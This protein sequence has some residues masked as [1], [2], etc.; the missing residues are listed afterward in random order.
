MLKR[1][2]T[3][4]VAA[5]SLMAAACGGDDDSG[6]TD[7]PDPVTE[8]TAEDPTGDT[9]AETAT[10]STEADPGTADPKAIVRFQW[11]T[12]GGSNY[13]P[14]IAFNQFANIFLYPAYDRLTELTPDGEVVPM[15]AESWEFTE[16]D[17][18]L[19]LAL[20][21]DVVFHDGTPFNAEAVK[22]NIE[23]G[24]T[25]EASAVT[26]DLAS[27]AEVV[28]VDEFTVE[29]RLSGPGAAL[30]A[31]L[32]DRA[33]MMISP[34]AF[35]NTDLD[36]RP[37]GAGAYMVKDHTPGSVI[38]FEQFPEYWNPEMQTLAGVE[39]TMQ[40]DPEARLRALQDG[41]IDGTTLNPDQIEAAESAGLEVQ[42]RPTTGAFLLFLNMT[43]PGLD[44]PQVREAI[45]LAIDRE[46]IAEALHYGKCA[47]SGQVFPEGYW[48][49]SPNV[50]PDAFDTDRA[51]S[52][53]EDAGHGDGLALD[54][55]VVNVPFYV[56]QLEALQAQLGEIGIDLTVTALEPTE[57]LSRFNTGGA[58]M[59]FT[60][61][62][63]SVDPAKTVASIF[64]EQASLNPGG[65]T[66]P[67]MVRLAEE[68]L[69]LLDQE[70]RATIYQELSE[71]AAGDRFHIVI[72]NPEAIYAVNDRVQNI[73]PTLGG[74]FDFRG[75]TISE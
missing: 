52:L 10:E 30:P 64:A 21:D 33:G 69:A 37:V 28:V 67:D 39:I 32:S 60:Q 58:D 4:L 24:Q 51:R 2:G 16:N 74:S 59:Y 70:D 17:T 22:A 9:T 66:N 63:G 14:H 75:V 8:D 44:N 55:V 49:S 15:L 61:Y 46:G 47:A 45:S 12:P 34:A 40:L 3:A 13:D 48:A 1:R 23:R 73:E 7:T 6:D 62:P 36:L 41:Q 56:A 65:Y 11:G 57:L 29:L 71:V 20:R 26:A 19:R 27:V 53:M 50:E 72:C 5:F 25:V 54:A 38:T 68:G 18:V 43:K 42:T 31:L 35:E